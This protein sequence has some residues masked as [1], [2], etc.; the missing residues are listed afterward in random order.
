V[1]EWITDAAAVATFRA[2][3]QSLESAQR[4]INLRNENRA[5]PYLNMNP[6]SITCG[7]MS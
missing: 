4:L 7:A 3:Q 6:S 5:E 1:E 2:F